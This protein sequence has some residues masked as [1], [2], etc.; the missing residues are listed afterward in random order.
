[1]IACAHEENRILAEDVRRRV[2]ADYHSWMQRW[3]VGAQLW[4]SRK[5]LQS[6]KRYAPPYRKNR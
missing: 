5:K 2:D 1:M 3:D 4:R 6:I